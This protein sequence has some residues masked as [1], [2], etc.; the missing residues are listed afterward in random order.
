M[1]NEAIGAAALG[2]EGDS[3]AVASPLR[4]L[5]SAT[6][7][8]THPEKSTDLPPATTTTTAMAAPAPVASASAAAPAAPAAA[9]ADA[10]T[11]APDRSTGLHSPP[12]SNNASKADGG[13]SDSE[14]SDLDDDVLDEA[15]GAHPAETPAAIAGAVAGAVAGATTGQNGANAAD[16]ANAALLAA[17][18]AD[19]LADGPAPDDD[20]G[21][22]EPDHYSGTVPVFRP[23]MHQF[24]DFKKFME[25]IDHYGMKSGIV[26]IIPPQEW[27][28]S[29]TPLDEMVKTI[30]VREPI[31]QDIMGSNGTYRQ[32]NIVHQRTYN[33]PQ[34]R[35]L[36]DQSEH[37]PPARRGERRANADKP[38]PVRA[39]TTAT[40]A[41]ATTTTATVS[42]DEATAPTAAT[43]SKKAKRGR[44]TRKRTRRT[45]DEDTA[46]VVSEPRPMTPESQ[47]GD[48]DKLMMDDDKTCVETPEDTGETHEDQ[49]DKTEDTVMVSVEEDQAIKKELNDDQDDGEGS[50]ADVPPAPRRI[51]FTRQASAKTQP[52]SARRKYAKREGSAKI[53]E[54]AFK[55]WDYRMDVSDYTPERC[56]ELERTYWKTLTYAQPLYGAD[57]PGTLFDE[58]TELW[59]LNKLPNL[60]DVLGTNVPGVNTAYLYLGMWKATFAWHLEDVDLYSINYL[61]FGAPKQWYSISQGDA[62]RF[63]AAMKNVWPA[64]AKACD[65]FLRHKAF[66]ISPSHLLQHYNIKVNKCVSYPGEFVVTYPY[67]Y[68][69]GYNLGYNCAE[70]VNFALESWLPM[71]KIAKKCECAQA[72]DSVWVDVYEIERKLRGISTD[73]E[74]DEDEEFDDE[75]EDVDDLDDQ[76]GSVLG[77]PT[78]PSGS[79]VVRIRAPN[80]KRKRRDDA[81]KG[82]KDGGADELDGTS[83]MGARR[84]K[85]MRLRLQSAEG[86]PC[87]LCPNDIP[88]AEIL[89]TD[90]GRRAHRICAQ[91]L[92]ETCIDVIN[93]QDVVTN[94]SD[95]TAARLEVRCMYCRMRK[96]V[97]FQCSYTRCSRA[98]HATCAAPAGVFVEEGQVPVFG[99]DG[100]EYKEQAFEFTCRFQR[101]K[102]DKK[103]D[104]EALE[105]NDRI[106]KAAAALTQGSVC[107]MQFYRSDIFAGVVLENRADEEMLLLHVIP[108]GDKVEVEWKWLLLP[109][110]GDYRLPKASPNALPLPSSR[111]EKEEIGAKKRP[112]PVPD[113][114][115]VDGYKWKEFQVCQDFACRN[116]DQAKVDL[117]KPEQLWYYLGRQST[118][119]KAHYTEDPARRVHNPRSNLL[120]STPRPPI[121]TMQPPMR[122]PALLSP[123]GA[124]A[125]GGN[126]AIPPQNSSLSSSSAATASTA[127]AA[128]AAVAAAATS[129][130]SLEP[131]RSYSVI[132]PPYVPHTSP[133]T[134]GTATQPTPKPS[135]GFQTP[136]RP[137]AK[138]MHS[139][140]HRQG[141][142]QPF[143]SFFSM[144]AGGNGNKF[145]QIQH[146]NLSH[147]YASIPTAKSS[148]GGPGTSMS[149]PALSMDSKISPPP[150]PPPKATP[151]PTSI[152]QKYAFFQVHCNRDPSG[153]RSPYAPPGGPNK[154]HDS[155]SGSR[156][157]SR[158]SLSGA[159][160]LAAASNKL[161]RRGGSS[162]S[163]TNSSFGFGLGL[164][165]LTRPSSHT[166]YVGP[167]PAPSSTVSSPFLSAHNLPFGAGPGSSVS[168]YASYDSVMTGGGHMS[169]QSPALDASP[170][171]GSPGPPMNA[172]DFSSAHPGM[173]PQFSTAWQ[174]SFHTPLFSQDMGD[175]N[176]SPPSPMT[177][178]ASLP[179]GLG[180]PANI[181]PGHHHSFSFSGTTM[182]GGSPLLS[183]SVGGLGSMSPPL[184]EES[185][186]A[187]SPSLEEAAP[188]DAGTDQSPADQLKQQL[189]SISDSSLPSTYRLRCLHQPRRRH[190][191]RSSLNRIFTSQLLDLNLT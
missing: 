4:F 135:D 96:G 101:T 103:Y 31:K 163:S 156:S 121:S 119:T 61:H 160:A 140:L 98:Y 63:E 6:I 167:P 185:P 58:A 13:S 165:G 59:N 42:T 130:S 33:L 128:A 112:V 44:A 174:Q 49:D 168:S 64:D 95:F 35:Q 115:F 88:F 78:P 152:G 136:R 43:G 10:T 158:Q 36:C 114:V 12:D 105:K 191:S 143:G 188:L 52:T 81:E 173:R 189:R 179:G 66:L 166:N 54:T 138:H 68:H 14:L 144:P 159:A 80:R 79:R 100:T 82:D 20:I 18:P 1:S 53:D 91:Y 29:L 15:L 26:K 22:I 107:Q 177:S 38:K 148:S 48:D 45:V 5:D 97:C 76:E 102:R 150:P 183:A 155:R 151:L 129:S 147:G 47:R 139:G 127:N 89:P 190:Q 55:D 8:T 109:E 46:S 32:V 145:P 17:L 186:L 132:K 87:C 71:G 122:P 108:S 113:D 142:Q 184:L 176:F 171:V 175:I 50:F 118:D 180:A 3:I 51:G 111:K 86:S 67:G 19:T 57:L 16:A 126:M 162:V 85:R 169:P 131:R 124:L 92:P 23:T 170:F 2:G 90:D 123:G 9:S 69:S 116:K 62:R 21:D 134:S 154:S 60:L 110:A 172:F 40:T 153:Y 72:Q 39:R 117:S 34:W 93:G 84:L 133:I 146:P 106:R 28:D 149:P 137:S 187:M 74:E 7:T 164:K 83:R 99:D 56:E 41:S 70:A 25:K 27:K 94:V 178:A 141:Q 73:D 24:R 161:H 65:Q 75:M 104:G 125:S 157:R 120:S 37:Q 11:S 77:L 30:K 182:A 181:V